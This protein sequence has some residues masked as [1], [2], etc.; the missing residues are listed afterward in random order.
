MRSESNYGKTYTDN[1]H[2]PRTAVSQHMLD[3]I[4]FVANDNDML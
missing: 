3:K 4:M 2:N 1:P